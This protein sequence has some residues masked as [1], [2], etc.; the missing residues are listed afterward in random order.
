MKFS[1]IMPLLNGA[2]FLPAAIASVQAQT[3]R[4]WE[5]IIADG[6]S[7]DGSDAIA[8]E[9]AGADDRIRLFTEPDAGMYDALLKGL[10]QARGEW[11]G[12]LNSDDLYTSWALATIDEFTDHT[13]CDWVT[14]VPACWDDKGRLR[15]L[16]PA[17]HYSQKRIAAGWHHDRLLGNLQQESIFFSRRLFER[18]TP[19]EIS[20]IRNMKLAGDYYLWR[21]FARHAPLDVIPSVLG[22]FRRH[23]KNMST[24]NAEDYRKEVMSTQ[25]FTLPAPL[26]QAAALLW[27]MRSSW[28]LMRSANEA[29]QK[30]QAQLRKRERP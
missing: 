16:R 30:M 2:R 22:G 3:E 11:L 24:V 1:I 27:R 7:T 28:E 12:W 26:A 15:Y 9:F 23:E 10:A 4:D 13:E 14:G 5:L 25:P 20:Q 21:R 6:G 29:D 8:R 18:L 17:G 19:D